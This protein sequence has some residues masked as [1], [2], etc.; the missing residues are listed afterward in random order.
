MKTMLRF[1]LSLGMLA[2]M[3]FASHAPAKHYWLYVG[4]YTK[5]ESKG[6]Y[7]Y[8]YNSLS[9]A[10]TSIGLVAEA[11]NPSWLAADPSGKYLYA[12]NETSDYEGKQSG[13]ITAFSINH[14]TGKL[15]QLN[16]VASRGADPC[17]LSFDKTGKFA[18]VANY[19]GGNIAAFPVL[20]DGRIGEA[21]AFV[22]H[23]GKGAKPQ[24]QA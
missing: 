24:H 10:L 8:R 22:Q 7:D 20:S 21:S 16:Q 9:G 23:S 19:S 2:P 6:I 5:G 15:T 13:A 4:T 12:A 3:I 11:V 1:L 17:Y 14:S 18:L